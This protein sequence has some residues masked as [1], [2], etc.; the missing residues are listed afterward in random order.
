[1]ADQKIEKAKTTA[2]EEWK[3]WVAQSTDHSTML[4]GFRCLYKV[5]EQASQGGL[6][7]L[8]PSPEA[9]DVAARILRG[10]L[11]LDGLKESSP[12][13]NNILLTGTKGVGKSTLMQAL[14]IYLTEV[15]LNLIIVNLEYETTKG[16][17]PI[18][19]SASIPELNGSWTL[20]TL[21]KHCAH[22]NKRVVVFADEIQELYD[23]DV[24]QLDS[25][26]KIIAEL[27]AVGKSPL[28]FGVISGS[29]SKTRRL[30]H[31]HEGY[32]VSGFSNLNHSVFVQHRMMPA[33]KE[34]DL[35][36]MIQAFCSTAK[37][38]D[39]FHVTG[40]VARGVHAYVT[41]Q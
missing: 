7:P 5:F 12:S 14:V 33:R 10:C 13:G 23:G 6:H 32:R 36:A 8:L 40:G 4:D 35:K 21:T 28:A 31:C 26:R 20:D 15:S 29:A 2:K 16:Q 41:A 19:P 37:P 9:D 24:A 34:D 39:V 25:G 1:M 22:H 18:L 27:I 38:T 17:A 30:V 11:A 3:N